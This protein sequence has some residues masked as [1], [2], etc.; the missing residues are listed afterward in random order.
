MNAIVKK[1]DVCL[2]YNSSWVS[3]LSIK[4]RHFPSINAYQYEHD[5]MD[6]SSSI[7]CNGQESYLNILILYFVLL[8]LPLSQ[9]LSVSLFQA[10]ILPYFLWFYI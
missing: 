3:P 7:F 8:P 4:A 5:F 1:Y 6:A 9:L 2:P 10:D